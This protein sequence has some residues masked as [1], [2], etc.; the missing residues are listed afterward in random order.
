MTVYQQKNTDKDKMTEKLKSPIGLPTEIF[1][2]MGIPSRA[3]H[4]E[5]VARQV[6]KSVQNYFPIGNTLQEN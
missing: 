2:L 3:T 4:K 5:I 1:S 6:K